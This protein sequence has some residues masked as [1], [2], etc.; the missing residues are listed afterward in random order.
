MELK[1][2]LNSDEHLNLFTKVDYIADKG[3]LF[4]VE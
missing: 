1:N 2:Y 3:F 4:L